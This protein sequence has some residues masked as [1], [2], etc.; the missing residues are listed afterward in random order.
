MP[1]D[2]ITIH[3]LN[4]MKHLSQKLKIHNQKFQYYFT[5]VA[6]SWLMAGSKVADDLVLIQ[7][8]LLFLCK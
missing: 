3:C 8:P 6:E 5:V 4:T 2:E 1:T 7:T